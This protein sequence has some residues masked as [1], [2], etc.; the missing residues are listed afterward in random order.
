MNEQHGAAAMPKIMPITDRERDVLAMAIDAFDNEEK[1]C[2]WLY[3]PNIQT[4]NRPPIEMIETPE[5]RE[6]VE[7]VL[8]QIKYAMFG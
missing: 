3:E 8:N 4:D 7:V 1:A 6:V 2:R 5:G